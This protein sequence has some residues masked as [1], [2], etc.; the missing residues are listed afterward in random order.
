MPPT[1]PARATSKVTGPG[2]TSKVM[3]DSANRKTSDRLRS[4][5]GCELER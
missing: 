1:S 2:V 5:M 3:T 4:D